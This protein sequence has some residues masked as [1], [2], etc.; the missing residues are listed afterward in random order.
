MVLH[1]RMRGC[2]LAHSWIG[3]TLN[4]RRT[5]K[6]YTCYVE[7][8]GRDSRERGHIRARSVDVRREAGWAGV[9]RVQAAD[10][11]IEQEIKPD[12]REIKQETR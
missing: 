7:M 11:E 6:H 2:P 5:S 9:G 3:Q 1:S 10:W 12:E 8:P 4:A